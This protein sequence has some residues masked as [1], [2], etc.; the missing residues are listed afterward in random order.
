MRVLECAPADRI[1]ADKAAMIPLPPVAPVT[2]WHRAGRLPRDHYVRLDG[3]D[4]SVDP[5]VIGRRI[6]ITADLAR[7]RVTCDGRAVADHER[8]WARHQTITDPSHL[9][10]AQAMRAAR[11]LLA[12]VKGP[13]DA[14]VE[15]RDLAVYDALCGSGEGAA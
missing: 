2:G 4:Y 12:P 1:A 13:G 14:E 15:R 6:Q 7:V 10:A 11:R 9:A 8:C 5:A 3:N